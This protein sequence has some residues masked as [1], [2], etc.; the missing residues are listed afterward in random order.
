MTK[1][2]SKAKLDFIVT[3]KLTDTT[4]G[5]KWGE[6]RKKIQKNIKEYTK[7]THVAL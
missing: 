5:E 4:E 6:N 1:K 7:I 2:S 3:I